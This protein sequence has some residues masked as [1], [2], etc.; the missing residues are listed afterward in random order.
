M[1]VVGLVSNEDE[2]TTDESWITTGC[3]DAITTTKSLTLR[4]K[5]R[6][7][8]PLHIQGDAMEMMES[9]KFCQHLSACEENPT[10]TQIE[11]LQ[12]LLLHF[13]KPVHSDQL[14]HHLVLKRRT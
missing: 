2:P 11:R 9:L 6:G 5:A 8:S 10:K 7:H 12:R 14:R 3:C 13:C 4:S 1:T